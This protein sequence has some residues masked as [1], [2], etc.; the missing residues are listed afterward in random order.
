MPLPLR[1][2]VAC[3]RKNQMGPSPLYPEFG[4]VRCCF[5]GSFD[6][7]RGPQWKA[8][9]HICPASPRAPSG[10]AVSQ[11]LAPQQTTITKLVLQVQH[12]EFSDH[13]QPPQAGKGRG[14]GAQHT[15]C[16][17][18]KISNA[19]RPTRPRQHLHRIMQTFFHH[20]SDASTPCNRACAKQCYCCRPTLPI[21]H[22][23]NFKICQL[24]AVCLIRSV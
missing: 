12:N 14:K 18:L 19:L 9:G 15:Y 8:G 7:A 23:D 17:F 4:K 1:S 13:W 16:S 22:N 5:E 2:T 20:L 10:A 24:Q 21:R 11:I 3:H 6:G